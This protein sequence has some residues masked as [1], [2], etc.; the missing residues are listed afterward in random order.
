MYGTGG[1]D[2]A[3]AIRDSGIST[4]SL[5]RH[6]CKDRLSAIPIDTESVDTQI[7]MGCLLPI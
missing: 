5:T 1:R 4:M 2:I 6:V 3:V 7:I